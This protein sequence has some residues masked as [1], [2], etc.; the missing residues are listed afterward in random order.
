MKTPKNAPKLNPDV[1]DGKSASGNGGDATNPTTDNCATPPI[2]ER[3]KR[4]KIELPTR[5]R[6]NMDLFIQTLVKTARDQ[7]VIFNFNGRLATVLDLPPSATQ[8][9]KIVIVQLTKDN[10]PELLEQAW[11]FFRYQ[12]SVP[13]PAMPECISRTIAA[14]VIASP[15]LLNACP[16]LGV[17][18][19]I[20]LPY[21]TTDQKVE[22]TP[23]G[24]HPA[25]ET[26]TS[27]HAIEPIPFV[28]DPS[29]YLDRLAADILFKSP[30]DRAVWVGYLIT[31]AAR[32]IR[33]Q[34]HI[35]SPLH[36][37][38]ANSQ[39][40]GKD[41]TAK[42]G[43]NL[44]HGEAVESTASED[45]EK[46]NKDIESALREGKAY[47]EYSNVNHV[48]RSE[49]LERLLTTLDLDVRI[50]GTQTLSSHRHNMVLVMT[51]NTPRLSG[52]LL[53]RTLVVSLLWLGGDPNRR[54]YS[55]QNLGEWAQHPHNRAE[56]MG[57]VVYALKLAADEGWPEP[58][59]PFASFR[60]WSRYIG[61]PAML[62]TGGT[63]YLDDYADAQAE[64]RSDDSQ[65]GIESDWRFV[66]RWA[67]GLEEIRDSAGL[68]VQ[69]PG[70]TY[71]DQWSFADLCRLVA[72]AQEHD[73][74]LFARS[75]MTPDHLPPESIHRAKCSLG[76]SLRKVVGRDFGD[77]RISDDGNLRAARRIYTL[78]VTQKP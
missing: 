73:H 1:A 40:A 10:A 69:P 52:D 17:V 28:G 42:L 41:E 37:F 45:E 11:D 70:P 39:R 54:T 56:F 57:F 13:Y 14:Q 3:P 31:L 71:T 30:R 76:L 61:V 78:F 22:L 77:W 66:V 46:L 29:A 5:G 33:R 62:A 25:T 24:Y 67:L 68:R 65:S 47:R 49:L 9:A 18:T 36:F 27:Q 64:M 48:V 50:F 60:D 74:E 4:P 55:R 12:T 2:I 44:T 32:I 34:K 20:R 6:M 16:T 21:L 43:M 59:T 35:L 26:Y 58:P 72:A 23:L 53:S 19:D 63:D 7:S 51:G 75:R 8:P 38:S 15:R